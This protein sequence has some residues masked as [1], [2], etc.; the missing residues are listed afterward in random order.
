MK[1]RALIVILSVWH[2]A[3]APFTATDPVLIDDLLSGRTLFGEPVD[4]AA[5][6]TDKILALNDEMRSYVADKTGGDP[7]ARSRLRKLVRGMLDDGF[8]TLDY[9]PNLTYTAIET[10][11]N[12]EGN[13][14]SFSILFAALAREAGLELTFQ[15]VEIP[16]SFR[17][18]GEL[19]LLNNHINILVKGVR[20]DINHTGEYVVDFNTAE[21]N[22]NYATRRVDDNYAIALYF[23]NVAVESMQ[24]GESR[25]AFQFLKKGIETDPD[26]AG[27]WVNLGVLYSRHDLYDLAVRAY[28]EALSIQPSNKSALVNLA[29]A[30]HQ[31]GRTEEAAHYSNKVDYYRNRHPYY[32]YYLAQTA[33]QEGRLD[34]AMVH[35]ADAIRLKQDE[36]QF[37]FLRGLVHQQRK[38]Y[39]L[40]ARDYRKARDTAENARLVS[41][42]T[43]KLQALES[44]LR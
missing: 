43:R 32:H 15:M 6:R 20:R 30:L 40:A 16:P 3:C 44:D 2:A 28:Q 5:I 14:L 19:I 35:V 29:T 17:A 10:F 21:Y 22:G 38:A 31:L 23:S 4:T 42:Y 25:R 33:Y 1:R 13:C 24:A 36:H 9:D 34:D 26:I 7:Q 27:I 11:Q 18:D 8:L 39:E 12:R 37:Y 41:G